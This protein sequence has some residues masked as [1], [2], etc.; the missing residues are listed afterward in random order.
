MLKMTFAFRTLASDI[1]V[2]QERHFA[3]G[4]AVRPTQVAALQMAQAALELAHKARAAGQ[5]DVCEALVLQGQAAIWL[6]L[7]RG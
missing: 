4:D 6:C 7:P 1:S 3:L 5:E 2:T